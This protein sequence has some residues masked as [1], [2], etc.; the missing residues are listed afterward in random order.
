MNEQKP[1]I[2]EGLAPKAAAP[3][4]RMRASEREVTS[5]PTT[6]A[7]PVE[8][9]AVK[10]LAKTTRRTQR[11]ASSAA[12]SGKR[13]MSFY[14]LESTHHRARAAS[15]HTRHPEGDE[16][17][18]DM[19]AKAPDAAAAPGLPA[20]NDGKPFEGT[21]APLPAGRPMQG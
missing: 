16:S 8:A 14:A 10:P 18:P 13:S 19:V 4:A 21:D 20:Y 11:K 17:P 1:R 3:L 9:P 15:R 7:A 2:I 5:A 6:P 12:T